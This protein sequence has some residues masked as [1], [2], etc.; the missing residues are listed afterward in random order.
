MLLEIVSL[1]NNLACV[2]VFAHNIRILHKYRY[3]LHK[4]K[5]NN[6]ISY[7]MLDKLGPYAIFNTQ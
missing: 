7:L 4:Y 1:N 2:Q 6:I 5:K 3:I